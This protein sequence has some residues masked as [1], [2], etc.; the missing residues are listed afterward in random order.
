MATA[1]PPCSA[2][3]ADDALDATLEA[4]T[5]GFALGM[6]YLKNKKAPVK[7]QGRA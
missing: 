3:G 6:R 5:Y 7:R 2:G 4:F 1:F